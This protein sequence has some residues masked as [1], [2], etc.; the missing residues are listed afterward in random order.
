MERNWTGEGSNKECVVLRAIVMKV[1]CTGF[2][3]V[4]MRQGFDRCCD[5]RLGGG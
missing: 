2:G 5:L 4:L 1:W 3:I